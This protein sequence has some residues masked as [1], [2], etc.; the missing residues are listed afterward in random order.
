MSPTRP[1]ARYEPTAPDEYPLPHEPHA[2]SSAPSPGLPY[3]GVSPRTIPSERSTWERIP[4]AADLELH[5]RRP[6]DRETNR[7]LDRLL[8]FARELFEGT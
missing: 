6:L 2:P 5:V 4:L 8:A 7:R 1:S 3:P